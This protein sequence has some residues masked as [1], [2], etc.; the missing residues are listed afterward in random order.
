MAEH[1]CLRGFEHQEY[2]GTL[3]FEKMLLIELVS[4]STGCLELEL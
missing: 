2:A 4:V 3:S 1:V